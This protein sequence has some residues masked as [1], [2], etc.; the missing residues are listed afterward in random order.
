MPDERA[1]GHGAPYREC[2]RVI[3]A[4][5]KIIQSTIILRSP[6]F[7]KGQIPDRFVS[8]NPFGT[9]LILSA[10]FKAI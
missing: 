2:D 4:I 8:W 5:E 6:A 3:Y 1:N 7:N 10:V 9:Y